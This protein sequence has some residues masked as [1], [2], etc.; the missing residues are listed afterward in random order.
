MS[1]YFSSDILLES[2]TNQ[3]G[4]LEFKISGNSFGINVEKIKQLMQAQNVQP[5]PHSHPFVEGIYQ[6]RDEVYTLL[7]LS[8]YLGLGKSENPEKDIYLVAVFNKMMVG[9]HVHGVEQIHKISWS[10][11]EKPA[12]MVFG[13]NEGIVTGITKIEDRIIAIL[14]FEKITY[15]ISPE[16]GIQMEEVEVFASRPKSSVPI[17]VAEDSALLRKMLMEA[18]QTAGFTNIIMTTDGEAAWT[19]LQD[20]KEHT[21][22][23]DDD[24]QVV[25]TD[26]EMPLMDGHRLTKLI[27]SDPLLRKLPVIIFSSLI[28][29]SSR[30][31]GH[32]VG[33]DEQL[34]KPEIGNL[35][36]VITKY[37]DK[38]TPPKPAE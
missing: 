11:I 12:S 13:G 28:N 10:A 23:L 22:N 7:D 29:E 26:I 25:I 20:V 6:P 33:A 2:G 5:I 3:L 4:L 32:E 19:F 31:K 14:D 27:K 16:T 37:L 15:D 9:F 18:L 21:T 34:T 1:N 8:G 24:V 38:D 36:S 35:V 17:L 30:L